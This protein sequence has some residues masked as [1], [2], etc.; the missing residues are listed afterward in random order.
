[1]ERIWLKSYDPKTPHCAQYPQTC[2]PQV[3]EKNAR[4]FPDNPAVEFFGAR[5]AYRQLFDHVLRLA[6]GLKGIGVEVGAKVAIMLPNTPQCVIAYYAALWLG[7]T[8]V[9]TNP[10]YVER[11]LLHQWTDSEAEFLFTLDHLYPKVQTVLPKTAI[12]STIVTSIKDYLPFPLRYLYPVKARFQK[13]FQSVPYDGIRLLSFRK[14]IADNRPEPVA[15]GA[16]P[17]GLALLQYTG[18][19]TGTPKGAMLTHKNLVANVVQLVSWFP[20]MALGKERVLAVLP[21]FHV[22]GMTVA[23]NFSLYTASAVIVVPRF[24]PDELIKTIKKKRPTLFPGVPAIYIAIMAHPKVDSFDL[25]SIRFCVTG[26]SAMPVDI[27]RRFEQKT[28]S[29]IIEGYGLSEASP[30]THVNPIEGTRKPGSIGLALPDT[31]CRIV[32]PQSGSLDVAPGEVGELIVSGPQVM[33]GYWKRERETS[34]ALREGWLYTGDLATMDSEGYVFIV[35]RKKDMVISSG[36]NVY[37]REIEEV[38]YEHPK[39]VDVAAIGVPHPKRGEVLKVFVVVKPGAHL[40]SEEILAWCKER[41]AP[42]KVPKEIEFSES[43]P[44]TNVG[45]VLRR[46]LRSKT[47]GEPKARQ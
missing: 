47:G 34:E 10:L 40:T 41:L 33:A 8:V 1:M 25:T 38:L 22:L 15:C 9:M 23:L 32:D 26:A 2:I 16:R 36:Y 35:D 43:L 42:Y 28:G 3:L 45:K 12:R 30:V 11:E 31:D 44:K 7:A 27:L 13:L 20:D 6:N 29:T 39:V 46:E 18:G 14:M 21:F 37:P 5:L 19:T 17:D 24:D 4:D